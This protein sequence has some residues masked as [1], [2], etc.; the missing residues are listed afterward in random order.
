MVKQDSILDILSSKK[1]VVASKKASDVRIDKSFIEFWV[2]KT[3]ASIAVDSLKLL[4]NSIKLFEV[5]LRFASPAY[6]C[7]YLLTVKYTSEI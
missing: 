7:F 1:R 4:A 3:W 6:L 5:W 2:S